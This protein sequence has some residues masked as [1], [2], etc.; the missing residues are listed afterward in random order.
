MTTKKTLIDIQ[1][2]FK[3]LQQE[4]ITHDITYQQVLYWYNSANVNDS[5]GSPIT[6]SN[7]EGI[8]WK[9]ATTNN[10]FQELIWARTLGA[11]QSKAYQYN[12]NFLETDSYEFGYFFWE[13]DFPVIPFHDEYELYLDILNRH[14]DC[15]MLC[16]DLED[17]KKL[18][19]E[20]HQSLEAGKYAYLDGSNEEPRV[21]NLGYYVERIA[22][23][24]GI[25]VESD[26]SIRSIRQAAYVPQGE[27]IPA[28][29]ALAQWAR[30]QGGSSQGQTGGSAEEDRDG[31]AYDI[32]SNKFEIDPFTGQP[33]KVAQG[34]YALVENIPQ[35][36]EIILKDLDK[37][38]GL[39]EGSV[40]LIPSPD[41][42]TVAEYQGINQVLTDIAFML[43]SLSRNIQGGHISSLINQALLQELLSALGLPI[44]YKELEIGIDSDSSAKIPYPAIAQGAPTL[45]DY[46]IWILNNLGLL[47]GNQ[48]QPVIKE[49][50]GKEN[51][52]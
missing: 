46:Y 1:T 5:I 36:L 44:N 40:N 41:G 35:L 6:F 47:I 7:A 22:R 12:F 50:E 24:L 23:V 21:A 19:Q 13:N 37:A 17:L 42:R 52:A 45:I 31:L 25:S 51:N 10:S 28:G 39:G 48:I 20:I 43:S 34:G 14:E 9:G 29:W 8:W 4:I 15:G 2:S 49:E 16:P 33:T 18:V 30:N 27:N 3:D 32:K 38:V 26:G 11:F